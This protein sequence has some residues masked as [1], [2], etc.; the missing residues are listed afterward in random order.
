MKEETE[1][2]VGKRVKEREEKTGKR[3]TRTLKR[4]IQ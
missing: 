4:L 2:V 3:L 1:T